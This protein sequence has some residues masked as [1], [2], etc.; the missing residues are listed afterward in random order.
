[1]NS[2]GTKSQTGVHI[3]SFPSGHTI[4]IE[5]GQPPPVSSPPPLCFCLLGG[6]T[7]GQGRSRLPLSPP[8]LRQDCGAGPGVRTPAEAGSALPPPAPGRLQPP[9]LR[10]C[11]ARPGRALWMPGGRTH[12]P[13]PPRAPFLALR[14]PLPGSAGNTLAVPPTATGGGH[15]AGPTANG[16]QPPHALGRARAGWKSTAPRKV[17]EVPAPRLAG[18]GA[19]P[20]SFPPRSVYIKLASAPQTLLFLRSSGRSE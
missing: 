14:G 17:L 11:D 1:M 15:E 10:W 9:P 18:R 13:G 8:G 16:Q 7:G 2:T 6:W 20:A 5:G 19:G 4:P 12:R 3:P